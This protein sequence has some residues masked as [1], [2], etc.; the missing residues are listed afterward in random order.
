MR[1]SRYLTAVAASAA[2]ALTIGS[3]AAAGGRSASPSGKAHGHAENSS[4]RVAHLHGKKS[5]GAECPPGLKCQFLPAAYAQNSAS[6]YDYGNY[7]LADRPGGRARDPLR[8]RPRHRGGL[9]PDARGVPGLA[10]VRERP[11]RDPL[12][13][14]ARHADGADEGR[15]LARR[16]L[17]R[18]HALRR[19]R[20]RGLRAAGR[21]VVHAEALPLARP[22][23]ALPGEAL[24]LP[25]R[26]RARHRPRPG[27]GAV[28]PVPGRDALGSG[29][30]LRLGALHGACRAPRS[31][32]SGDAGT[33]PIVTI[34]PNWR[35]NEP[36]VTGCGD[37]TAACPK[38]SANFVYLHT[39]P[40]ATARSSPIHT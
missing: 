34:D 3:A 10:R 15:R 23:D 39:A 7:D 28:E 5:S 1:S 8:R 31:G 25:A 38:Q 37:G 2:L 17:V 12:L 40:S 19:D 6:P 35:T 27:A 22:A 29:P 11:L 32:R 33:D 24:R 16:Q 20:E 21:A 36:T 18:E 13:G 26:P 4:A 14:R 30:L 9:R